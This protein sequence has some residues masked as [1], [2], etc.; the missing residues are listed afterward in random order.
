[1]GDDKDQYFEYLQTRSFRGLAYRNG[2]LYPR[3]SRHLSG[4][5][6]DVGCGI[7]DMLRFRPSTQGVDINPHT[8]DWCRRNGLDASLMQPDRLPFDDQSFDSAILDNVLEHIVSPGALLAELRRVLKPGGTLLVGVPGRKGYACDPDHKVFYDD[9]ALRTTLGAAGFTSR[10]VFGM[11]F[12]SALLDR[13]LAL[14]CRYGVFER[15]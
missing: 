2:W 6:L 1:M 3:L 11:P 13:H 7:G 12:G 15:D 10:K 8:V 9:D 4:K 14:Y 5:A